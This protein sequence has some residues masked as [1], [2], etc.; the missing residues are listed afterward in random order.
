MTR[1]LVAVLAACGSS[2]P[3]PPQAR[4]PQQ[5]G[6]PVVE[7]TV[8]LAC[9]ARAKAGHMLDDLPAEAAGFRVTPSTRGVHLHRD[10]RPLTDAEGKQMWK[11]IETE[12]FDHGSG[13]VS[14]AGATE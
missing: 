9:V 13:F 8:D 1:V 4:P 6:K 3:P 14:G 2:T 5:V 10:G 7:P 11:T 12:L